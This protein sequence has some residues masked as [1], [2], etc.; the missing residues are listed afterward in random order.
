MDQDDP[1]HLARF[2]AAQNENYHDAIQELR[3]GQKQTHWAWYVF[4]QVAGL[5]TSQM[6]QKYAIQSRAEAVAYLEHPVLGQRLRACADALLAH[7]ERPIRSIMGSPDDMKLRS[8][9]TLFAAISPQGSV[10][11]RVLEVFFAGDRD[12]P[13][14]AFLLKSP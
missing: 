5:G 2:L 12:N 7:R 3:D 10:F 6:A 9:M 1:H 13:T 14:T 4:P 11:H 8:S